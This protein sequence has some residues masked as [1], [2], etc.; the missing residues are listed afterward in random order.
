[1]RW[2]ISSTPRPQVSTPQLLD[3]A[4]SRS[5][6]CSSNASISTVGMPYRPNPP[7][8]IVEPLAMSATASAA[9]ATTLSTSQDLLVRGPCRPDDDTL[10]RR[11][12]PQGGSGAADPAGP[13]R[14]FAPG[15]SG[16]CQGR[17]SLP[18]RRRLGRRTPA[19]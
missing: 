11:G 18:L 15:G 6:P 10:A 5:A 17:G 14:R 1:M 16:Y 9:D 7:T 3:T 12:P 13:R 2:F 8:A 19:R 4:S